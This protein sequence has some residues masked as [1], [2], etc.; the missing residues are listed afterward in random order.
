MLEAVREQLQR[1]D[2]AATPDL[3]ASIFYNDFSTLRKNKLLGVTD[4][5][6]LDFK[7]MLHQKKFREF[8][9]TVSQPFR[10]KLLRHRS[11]TLGLLDASGYAYGDL[12]PLFN[13]EYALNLY[14]RY[15]RLGHPVIMLPQALGPFENPRYKQ[16][17]TELFACADLIYARD[18][19]SYE[20]ASALVE[21]QRKLKCAPDFTGLVSPKLTVSPP[22]NACIIPNSR[23][24]DTGSTTPVE[25][26]KSFIAQAV[27]AL[28]DRGY[29]PFML[30]HSGE[31]DL[32]L[33]RE[34]IEEYSL[35]MPLILGPNALTTKSIIS[36]CQL[37][38]SSR[39]HGIVNGLS[40]CIPTIGTSW[41]HKYQALFEEHQSSE[42]LVKDLTTIEPVLRVLD[43]KT[44]KQQR[45]KLK[46]IR[47]EVN[48]QNKKMW[49]EIAQMLFP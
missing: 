43:E 27:R 19:Y 47:H 4:T 48:R 11:S 12:W 7:V 39:Y 20:H 21:N 15:K 14:Q 42:W 10:K 22:G 29:S 40:Q 36:R 23:M 44:L 9:L 1:Q 33:G 2:L 6:L 13:L 45:G 3:G 46:E 30:S 16:L 17:A 34:I 31:E 35:N 37:V 25:T 8:V 24:L 28:Q 26:Y 18:Q 32:A 49:S 41:S 5:T 38:I